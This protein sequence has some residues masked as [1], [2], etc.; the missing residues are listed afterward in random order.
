MASRLL[1]ALTTK[2]TLFPGMSYIV[3]TVTVAGTPAARQVRLRH[4][5]SGIA[6]QTTFSAADGTYRFDALDPAEEYDV[7]VVDYARSYK[8]YIEPAVVPTA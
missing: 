2:R 6:V 4:R 8:D 3:G 1:G 5:R 7:I